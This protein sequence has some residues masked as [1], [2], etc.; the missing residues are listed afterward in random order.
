M[1]I[2]TQKRRPK[3][4]LVPRARPTMSHVVDDDWDGVPE[5]PWVPRAGVSDLSG[6]IDFDLYK[7][8]EMGQCHTPQTEE[9]GLLGLT[10]LVLTGAQIRRR[11][12]FRG[13]LVSLATHEGSFGMVELS[14]GAN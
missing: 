9:H 10:G 3:P 2:H 11:R 7:V 1:Y 8:L 5:T 12:K 6:S 14:G 4:N 13:S